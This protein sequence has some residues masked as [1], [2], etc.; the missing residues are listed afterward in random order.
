[1]TI[2]PAR[3]LPA[4]EALILSLDEYIRARYGLLAVQTFE[5]E[6]FLRFMRGVAE[7]ERHRAKGLYA[8]SRTRG[9]R[10]LA[11]PGVGPDPR[12]IPN[13]EDALSVIEYIEE[14]EQGLYVLA[15]FAPYVLEY[16]APKPELVRRLR[17]LAWTIRSRPVTV[18]FLGARFPEIPELE[19]EVKV[20]DLPLPEEAETG[21]ILDREAERLRSN[22]NATVDLDQNARANLVQALLGLTIT[23]MENVLAKAAAR[24]RGFGTNTAP[25]VLNEKRDLIRKSGAL[26]FTPALPIEHVGGYLPIRRLL[27]LAALTFTPEARAFGVEEAKGLLLVGLPG[28]GKDTIARAA[29]SVLGR[30]LLQLDLGA[31]MGEGGGLLGS[32]EINI[33]RALQIATTTKCVLNLSEYEKAVGGMRS[34]ARTDGGATSRVVGTLLNW[35]SEPHPGVFVIATANDVRELAP[36]Q[37]REG[38]FTPVFVDLPT[39]EDRAAIFGVHLKKRRRDPAEFDLELLAARSDGYSGAEIESTA[40]AALLQA[41]EDGQRPVRT[42]DVSMALAGI[43]PLAQVKAAEVEDLRRWAREALAVDANRGTP[44]GTTEARSLEL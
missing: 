11:G 40:K 8:W 2:S 33:K 5:E 37:I 12:L 30:A 4:T 24:D 28:C 3:E 35:L 42:E 36:E 9:L 38:R 19:K 14:A 15:D 17:E 6:R 21:E 43:R 1:M 26:T 7:H 20:L 39:T 13:R 16:G 32:A 22:P 31:V 23:E 41:F 44:V 29:S 34:S 27:R 18:I 25:L 10:L